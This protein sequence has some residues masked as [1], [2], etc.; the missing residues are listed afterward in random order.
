MAD[1]TAKAAKRALEEEAK[2]AAA[3]DAPAE[4]KQKTE[5]EDAA[6]AADGAEQETAAGEEAEGTA[7][8]ALM[9]SLATACDS[10]EVFL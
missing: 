8:N 3:E 9:T 4:K 1:E 2:E 10:F 6:P 7:W 5:G